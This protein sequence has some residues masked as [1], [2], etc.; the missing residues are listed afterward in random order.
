MMVDKVVFQGALDSGSDREMPV[1][2]VHPFR[3]F[4]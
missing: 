4:R 1:D 2:G 3:R